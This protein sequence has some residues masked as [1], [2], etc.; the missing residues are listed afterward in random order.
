MLIPLPVEGDT[1]RDRLAMGL[2]WD[3][4]RWGI[5]RRQRP[6]DVD[7]NANAL[8]FDGVE[9]VDVVYS[10]QL[11]AADGAVRLQGDNLTGDG[12]GD[13]ELLTIELT[14]LP[15]RVTA[16]LLLVTSYTGQTFDDIRN[17]FCRL[18]DTRT[19]TEIVRHTLLRGPHTG[20]VMGVIVR[21]A[22][23]SGWLYREVA[24]G[25]QARHPVEALPHLTGYLSRP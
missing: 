10:E 11:S 16:V 12:T 14:R 2:G 19:G 17:G 23:E 20:M 6:H 22:D 18:L 21:A 15:E 24:A 3:P 9:L 1:P 7:L 4:P 8:L 25:I 13:D 5:F